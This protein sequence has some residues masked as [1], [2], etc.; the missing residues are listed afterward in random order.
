VRFG[1][2]KLLHPLADG[3][4][5]GVASLRNLRVAIPRTVAV[6]RAGDEELLR[7]LC[8]E[9]TPVLEC[10]D[11]VLGMGHSLAAAVAHESSA[12]GWVVALGDMPCIAPRTIAL[13]AQAL[14]R[15]AQIVVPVVAGKRGHPVGFA[16]RF[17]DQL[18][19]LR[20]DSGARSILSAHAAQI[21]EI[22]VADAG[23]VRDVDTPADAQRLP[24]S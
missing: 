11:A 24:G 8:A 3:T 23:I 5:L 14:A 10:A 22:E 12:S 7:L 17:R 19:A 2:R 21:R 4:P 9:G 16:R 13:I 6:V 15:G 20:G 18:I 1:G